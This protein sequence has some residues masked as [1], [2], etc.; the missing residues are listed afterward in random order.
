VKIQPR[1][2]DENGDGNDDEEEF[3]QAL[4]RICAE[5]RLPEHLTV[6]GRL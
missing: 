5:A 1:E 4:F 3:S 6:Q 2:A